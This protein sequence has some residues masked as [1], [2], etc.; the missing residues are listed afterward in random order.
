MLNERVIQRF[1]IAGNEIVTDR[2]LG[3]IL[4]QRYLVGVTN[5]CTKGEIDEI[6]LIGIINFANQKMCGKF[7]TISNS[8]RGCFSTQKLRFHP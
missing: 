6:M 1:Q 7:Y 2:S 3:A 4:S 5:Y 8:L